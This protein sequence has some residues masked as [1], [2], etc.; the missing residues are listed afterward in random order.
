MLNAIITVQRHNPYPTY[1]LLRRFRPALHIPRYRLWIVACY[2]DVKRVLSDHSVFS[3]DFSRLMS[4]S[5]GGP[6]VRASLI[7]ADP[8]VHTTLRHLVSRA[9]TPRVV[10]NLE[11][12][13]TEIAHGLLD[14]VDQRG[15]FDLIG[16]FAYPLPVI[17]I[18]EMLGVPPEDRAQFK[19]WS[20]R[21]TRSADR[22][23]TGDE[24]PRQPAADGLPPEM[25]DDL[26]PYFR[27]IIARRRAEPCDDLISRLIAAEID[28]ERLT[29]REVVAFCSL[30]LIAGNVT[31][32][33]LIG[34]A[35][36]LLLQHPAALERLRADP[37]LIPGALE[38]VLRHRSPVQ[39]MFRVA[40]RET[41]IQGRRVEAGDRIVA[42][43]GSANRDER[44]FPAAHRFDITRDPNPHIAFGHGVHYCL[45]APLARLEGRVAL[46]TLLE[47]M[48][49]LRR[50]GIGPL[51][52]ED[53]FILHGVKRLPLRF[54]GVRTA[55]RSRA[56]AD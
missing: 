12:R 2:D 38:E 44:R 56:A 1:W 7:A 52:P 18:A 21:L 54:V 22:F 23:F 53:A 55:L 8:P 9:F 26:A 13:V 19:I 40:A 24:T 43:I 36:R 42:L 28:G 39:F 3:S 5:S 27:G 46:T 6:R 11:P 17:V 16:D 51:E 32:T 37:S 33:N 14:E 35:M 15:R 49:R 45:G 25:V 4:A 31:T 47:R 41:E 48:R 30:L 29:E 20:E 50:V 34:N 10:A